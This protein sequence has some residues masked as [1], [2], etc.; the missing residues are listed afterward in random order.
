MIG[1]RRVLLAVTGGVA[2]FKVATLAR[3][4]IDHRAEVR[5]V[6]TVSSLKF[7]GA[8]TMAAITGR[9]VI[10]DLFDSPDSVSPHTEAAEW[11]DLVVVVPATAASLSRLA[12]GQASDPVSATVLAATC[13]IAVVPAMHTAMWEHPATRRNVDTLRS[14]GVAVLGPVSGRLAG[15]DRGAG[16]MVE[17][18]QVFSMVETMF[19]APLRG[20]RVVVTAGGTREAIDPVRFLSNH[21]SGKMG[22]AVAA[23][24][25]LRGAEI[26]LVTCSR[27]E[28][29]PGVKRVDVVSAHEMAEAVGSI[30]ADVAVMTAAVAD[31][32]PK[33]AQARKLA[34]GD[35][36]RMLELEATRD[37]LGEVLAR[38]QRPRV[39]V[40]FAAETGGVERAVAKA[41]AK[42]VDL[43][44]ANDVTIPGSGFESDNNQ[45]TLIRPGGETESWPLQSKTRVAERLWDEIALMLED[46]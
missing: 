31:F 16:R 8:N 41:K 3:M 11:A 25:A 4:L 22:H 9:P 23:E 15:G 30:E 40:G 24:A 12:H 6:M 32:R 5:A 36:L 10:T 33:T 38:R 13:P 45:V 39:V 7:L 43:M 44:V 37:V 19:E 20:V 1:G 18:D 34:R 46:D 29:H 21:S 26:T 27:L 28:S 2:A 14:D 35:G 17:P 42:G